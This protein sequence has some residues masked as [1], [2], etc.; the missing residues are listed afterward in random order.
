LEQPADVASLK[1]MVA[2]LLSQV[3]SM[4]QITSD[5]VE[6][7]RRIAP[8]SKGVVASSVRRRSRCVILTASTTG[9]AFNVRSTRLPQRGDLDGMAVL[10]ADVDHFKKI[11][12]SDGHVIATSPVERSPEILRHTQ[13]DEHCFAVGRR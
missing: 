9:M 10:A 4:Q 1:R 2:E 12:D 11:N 7:S 13:S 3:R 6:S 8:R 5:F